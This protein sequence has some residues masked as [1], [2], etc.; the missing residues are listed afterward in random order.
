MCAPYLICCFAEH[1]RYINNALLVLESS[2]SE[3]SINC[4]WGSLNSILTNYSEQ[5]EKGSGTHAKYKR[6]P[7]VIVLIVLSLVRT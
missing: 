7:T 6:H 5:F 2:Y 1:E 4:A 3:A